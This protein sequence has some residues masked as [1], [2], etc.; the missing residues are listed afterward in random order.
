MSGVEVVLAAG[1]ELAEGTVWDDRAGVLWWVDIF[2]GAVHRLDP[3]SGCDEHWRLPGSVGSLALC[4]DGDLVVALRDGLYRFS[5]DTGALI[6]LARPEPDKLRNRFNDGRT[7]RQGRF[8]IGSLHD[9]ETEP[10]GSLWRLDADHSC[11]MQADGIHASN[12]TAFSPDGRRGYHA[13]S[14]TGVVWSFDVDIDSGELSNRKPFIEL[15]RREGVPDGA[16]VDVDGCY[17]L[18]HAG[19]WRIARYTPDGRVDRVIPMP[20]EIPTCLAFG[21]SDGRTLFVTT[22]TYKLGPAALA[23]QPLAGHILALDTG[24]SGIPDAR[25]RG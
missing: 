6:A 1:A 21:G 4:E 3:A 8:W 15:E 17:W 5:P 18:T 13:D 7:D 9:P 19:G 22:A 25:Y 23:M 2:A 14:R 16:T 10:T 20:V 24:S 11:N 12:G